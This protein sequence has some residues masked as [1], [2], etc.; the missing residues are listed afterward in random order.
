M[1]AISVGGLNPAVGN[2]AT[3]LVNGQAGGPQAAAAQFANNMASGGYGSSD[4]YRQVGNSLAQGNMVNPAMQQAGAIA[5]GKQLQSN[6]WL[7]KMASQGQR[8]LIN[9]FRQVTAPNMAMDASTSGRMGGGL[10][11]LNRNKAQ[12]DT[13]QNLENYTSNF[14]GNAYGQE[15]AN[16]MQALGMQ[17][18]LG[19][20]GIQ[21]QVAGAGMMNDAFQQGINNRVQGAQLS[22]QLG[23]QGV[24]NA[25][26]GAG[27]YQQGTQNAMQGIQLGANLN[28]QKYQDMNALLGVGNALQ[29]APWQPGMQYANV[30]GAAPGMGGGQTQPVYKNPLGEGLGGAL[31][32]A[33][34]GGLFGGPGAAIGA[35]LGGLAG[36]FSDRRLKTDI[37]RVGKTD[38][39]HAVYT[40]RYKGDSTVRM[41]VMAQEVREKQPEAVGATEAGVLFVD[42]GQIS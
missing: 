12:S 5:S 35:G 29:Q 33:Q 7:D 11:A 17:G 2:L 28:S 10:Y 18:Q 6:P 3:R 20:Q 24:N 25:L 22:G 39:G 14:Y 37:R 16:Q 8:S 30:L 31:G 26:A 23:Q 36:L 40:Y 41:G 32:G 27:L 38:G 4:A 19:Q 21:N 1:P 34:I 13:Q 9:S 42:Y 15:R